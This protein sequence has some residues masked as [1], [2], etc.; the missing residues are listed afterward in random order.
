[1]NGRAAKLIGKV[2]AASNRKSGQRSTNL[3][4]L[5]KQR[6]YAQTRQEKRAWYRHA[7]E[8]LRKLGDNR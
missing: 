6:Y 7:H 1:M 3:R 2:V 4:A 5:M 8:M